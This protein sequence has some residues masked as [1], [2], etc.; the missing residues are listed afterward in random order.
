MQSIISWRC[1]VLVVLVLCLGAR[2]A[3]ADELAESVQRARKEAEDGKAQAQFTYAWFLEQGKGVAKNEVEAARW[4]RKAA[5]QKHAG[6]ENN[7]GLLYR[8]QGK[9]A[10]A[11]QMYQRA[12]MGFRKSLGSEHPSTV[13]VMS[14][15]KQLGLGDGTV[16]STS[17]VV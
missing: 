17:H 15:L 4:Y 7:L 5:E 6:A 2:T 10:E 8:G 16:E 14:N 13:I 1:G 12:L 3:S 11:E 9:L